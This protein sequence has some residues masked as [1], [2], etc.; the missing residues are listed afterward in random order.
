M[1]F[2]NIEIEE[3]IDGGVHI[4]Y[5]GAYLKYKEIIKRPAKLT[6]K[7]I[8]IRKKYIPLAGHP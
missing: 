1:A 8:K 3:R 5:N 7:V 4:K 6:E 2:M